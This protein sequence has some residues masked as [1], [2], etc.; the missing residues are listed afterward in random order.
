[1][2]YTIIPNPLFHWQKLFIKSMVVLMSVFA[3]T[4]YAKS[5]QIEALP[6]NA[7]FVVIGGAL[8]EIVYALNGQDRII[9]RDMTSTYPQAVKALPDI[10]YMRALSAENILSLAPQGILLVEGSGPEPTLDI[11]K[12]A[13][14]PMVVIPES[15]TREGVI[16]KVH[17]VGKA[18]GYQANANKL[19]D[20][21]NKDFDLTDEL[22]R[23]I[24]HKKKI[25][26]VLSVQNGRVM[27][28]GYDTAADGI[29]KLAGAENAITQ[30]SGYKLLNDEALLAAKPDMILSMSPT[31]NR[32]LTKELIN[33][34]AIRA[35][36]AAKNNSIKT[37]DGLYLLGFGPRTGAAARDLAQMLYGKNPAMQEK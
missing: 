11:L 32:S 6:Q 20:Q 5:E 7:K 33:L 15:F 23:K 28:A 9:A 10:G 3:L 12:K 34:P 18:L 35:T 8:T 22:T 24:T 29:I 36:P 2:F 31:A 21:I 4:Q 1:M 13:S 14:I 19:I 25:L 16:N 37:M 26:F 30:Y 17:S 27:A